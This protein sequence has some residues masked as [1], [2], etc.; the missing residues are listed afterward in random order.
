MTYQP[1]AEHTTGWI[2][3][4][5]KGPL[6][7]NHMVWLYGHDGGMFHIHNFQN[8]IKFEREQDAE[9]FLLRWS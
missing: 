4:K 1:Y 6:T 7:G 2:N 8:C 9:W 3:V 5:L